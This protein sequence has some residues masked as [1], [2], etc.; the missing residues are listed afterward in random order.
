MQKKVRIRIVKGMVG[1]EGREQGSRDWLTRQ[2]RKTRL[3]SSLKRATSIR[4]I[5]NLAD[6]GDQR[7]GNIV[8]VRWLSFKVIKRFWTRLI[9][10]AVLKRY[11]QYVHL[12][13]SLHPFVFTKGQHHLY[14]F[15]SI[16]RSYFREFILI[17]QLKKSSEEEAWQKNCRQ[18]YCMVLLLIIFTECLENVVLEIINI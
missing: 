18:V 1:W 8:V 9:C 4:T 6:K 12:Y 16:N 17:A 2:G 11:V 5:C 7:D 15:W 10:P 14:R 13:S 3:M